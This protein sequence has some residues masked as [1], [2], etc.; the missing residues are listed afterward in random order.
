MMDGRRAEL[1]ARI[2]A[3]CDEAKAKRGW[4]LK[5]KRELARA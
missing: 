1:T 2:M 3:L 5:A 4:Q